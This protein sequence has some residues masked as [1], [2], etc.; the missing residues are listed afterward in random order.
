MNPFNLES[1]LFFDR[2]DSCK[3]MWLDKGEL[4]RT[5]G[6]KEDFPD[7][8]KAKSGPK[9]SIKCPKCKDNNMIEFVLSSKS[10]I[11]LDTCP[12]CEGIWFDSKEIVK[13]KSIIGE[14]RIDQKKKHLGGM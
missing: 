13:V 12:K 2:C 3:G 6:E 8:E 9:S 5:M 4:A 14:M 10:S 1:D 7:P 11:I